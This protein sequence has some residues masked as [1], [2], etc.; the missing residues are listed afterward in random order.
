MFLCCARQMRFPLESKPF[1]VL[2][3]ALPRAW[4]V[5]IAFTEVMT[6]KP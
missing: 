4:S 3:K 2:D 5:P 1:E 6:C